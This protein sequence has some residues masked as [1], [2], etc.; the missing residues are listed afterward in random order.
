MPRPGGRSR[1]SAADWADAA[2]SALREGGG[3]AAI[4]IEPLAVRLGATKGSFYWHFT[5][6]E[7]LI[8]AALARWEKAQTEEVIAD[9]GRQRDALAR[10]RE[11]FAHVTALATRDPTELVLIG[12]A[13]HPQV[14]P[15]LRRVVARRLD[16]LSGL[17]VEL[18][19]DEKDARQRSIQTYSGYVGRAQLARAVPELLP[20]GEEENRRYLDSV[21]GALLAR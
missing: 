18:G 10:I 15:V 14:A 8:E 13:A 5:N 9:L 3:L 21:L 1:L 7:A 2:L 4:A 17:F 6:R 20:H 16:Y 11:L 19:L 12:E